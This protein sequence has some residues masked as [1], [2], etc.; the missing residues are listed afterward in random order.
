VTH[1]TALI[2]RFRLGVNMA[3]MFLQHTGLIGSELPPE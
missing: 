1:G 3:D 2:P